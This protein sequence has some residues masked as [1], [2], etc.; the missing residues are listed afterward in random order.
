[1]MPFFSVLTHAFSRPYNTLELFLKKK[2]EE[3]KLFSAGEKNKGTI[4]ESEIRL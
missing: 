4:N 1:M 3:K 2:S